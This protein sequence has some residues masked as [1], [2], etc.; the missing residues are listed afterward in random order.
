MPLSPGDKL[1]HYEILAPLGAGGMGEVY[2][3][4]DTRLNR[5]VAIKVLP[6]ALANDADYLARLQRE[7]QSLAALNHPNI[8]S[9]YGLEKNAIVMELVEG[10]TL[11]CPLP[12]DEALQIARQIAEALEAA[13]EKGIIH[14]DLKPANIKVTAGGT[15]KL[16]DFGL[17]KAVPTTATTSSADSPTLTLRATEA[18]LILGTAA[19]MAPEQAAGK[20][21]DRRA[22]IWAFGVVLWELL[23]GKRLFDGETVSHTLADV[24][25]AP[26]DWSQLPPET[27]PAIRTLLKRCLDRNVKDRLRDIGEARFIL[28]QPAESPKENPRKRPLLPWL[29]AA[30][31]ALLSLV[32]TGLLW[33]SPK[34]PPA[35]LIQLTLDLS[36]EP[37][38]PGILG[39]ALAL[40]PD[41]ARVAYVARD[42]DGRQRLFTRRLSESQSAPLAD[43]ENAWSPFFSPD[44]E[45]IGYFA[46]RK[47]KKVPFQG[48]RPIEL[49]T[50]NSN[51]ARGGTWIAD[52]N[53]VFSDSG[54]AL[55][56][57]SAAGGTA[58]VIAKFTGGLSARWPHLLPGGKAALLNT[59]A[60][61]EFANARLE[62][63]VLATGE[64]KLILQGGMFPR[65]AA[66]GHLLYI[67]DDTLYAAPFDPERLELTGA[68]VPVAPN[69][70][71]FAASGAGNLAISPNGTLIYSRQSARNPLLAWLTGDGKLET[72]RRLHGQLDDAISFSPDGRK[73]V[74]SLFSEGKADLWTYD[75]PR[76]T[77]SRLTSTPEFETNPVWAPSGESIVFTAT[78]QNERDLY[79]IRSDASGDREQLTVTGGWNQ[80]TGFSPRGNV[81]AFSRT[82]AGVATNWDVHLLPLSGSA[83]GTPEL[84][85][86][87]A[88][89]DEEAVFS[90]D[91]RWIAYGSGES[92]TDEVYVRA[93][94]AAPGKWQVSNRGGTTPVWSPKANELYYRTSDGIMAVTYRTDSN[95]FLADKPRQWAALKNLIA[96]N[97]TPDGRRFLVAIPDTEKQPGA[98]GIAFLQNFT[99]Q[100]AGPRPQ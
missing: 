64:R 18:G 98:T 23:T 9:I 86:A 67:R 46:D 94:P 89:R 38:P 93:Y 65:F 49:I 13:H 28:Q 8:A 70:G 10:E 32:L 25:R 92:G 99:G 36:P 34:T 58:T 66:S 14:R 52:G 6:A 74:F 57:L 73:F 68:A 20:P 88:A 17:A 71:N 44:G 55:S 60:P 79:R 22:D 26:I 48:G 35:G 69:V 100:Q 56:S 41:G 33:R 83:P 31:L 62:A 87:S 50:T 78:R 54:T 4:R 5:D 30:G 47:L 72:I 15:V 45:W 19:Y 2:R 29:A 43:T 80:A 7:G 59:A 63:I 53:I 75:W 96:Y 42:A 77:L 51:A 1:A 37:V 27:P 95:S 61:G 39:Y 40:S 76:D 81:L 21:L 3:A 16:L 85:A 84:F 11:R 82:A 90:P 97:I 24:L 91:G 12:I